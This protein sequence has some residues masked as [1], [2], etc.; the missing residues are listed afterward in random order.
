VIFIDEIDALGRKRA[1]DGESSNGERD[2][3]LN[4]LLVEMDG[5]KNNSGVFVLGATNRIDMLDPALV[6]PGRL[7]DKKIYIGVPDSKTR[8]AIVKQHIRGKP[9]DDS[10]D[11]EEM[12]ERTAGN[13]GA[14][15]ENLLN[16]AMLNALK[17][18][19]E[20]FTQAD[21][22]M[23]WARMVAGWQPVEHDFT[24]DMIL[25]ISIHEMGHAVVGMLSKHHSNMSRVTINLSSPTTP[26]MTT[27]DKPASPLH[28]R[29]ALFEHLMILLAGRIAEEEF[30][31]VSV[32]TGAGD[33]IEKAKRLAEQMVDNLMG[34]GGGGGSSNSKRRFSKSSQK[35]L[36]KFDD[37]VTDLVNQAYKCAEIIVAKSRDLIGE[38]AEYLR[39]Q[40]TMNAEELYDMI[41]N[42]YPHLLE[43]L[44]D[45]PAGD[46]SVEFRT[47]LFQ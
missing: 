28:K 18:G 5:F 15:I 26:G 12:I 27:F 19:R 11:M 10:F 45:D 41:V 1:G 38:S 30:Y 6:R 3:T 8:T 16:E 35:Y 2:A 31:G 29:E 33:D 4:A 42:K 23:V 25:Q 46:S 39:K 32:T 47:D 9:H 20:S 40:K 14:Q 7:G 17:E 36:E 34:V 22:D 13:S 44:R 21:F 24:E 37:E 43:L